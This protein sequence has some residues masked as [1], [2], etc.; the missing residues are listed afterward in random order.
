MSDLIPTAHQPAQADRLRIAYIILAHHRPEAVVRLVRRL[1][2]PDHG[3]FIHFNLRSPDAEFQRLKKDLGDLPNVKLL[4]RQKCLWGDSGMI[5]ATLARVSRSWPARILFTI[6]RCC[7]P[8]RITPSSR[9]PKSGNDWH[10]QEGQSYME[11]TPHGRIPNWEKGRAIKR[12]ENFHF[13]LPVP[14]W[15]RSLGW[16]P[17]W[18]HLTVPMKRKIPGDLHPHFG[19]AFWCLHRTCLRYIHD[20]VT[21]HPE[22][23]SF[24]QHALLP[25]ECLLQTLLMN[26]ALAPNISSRILTYV[27]WRPPWPGILTVDD[28]PELRRSDCLLAR[29][30]DTATDGK[31]LD[32]L[33]SI[34]GMA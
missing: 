14:P 29:K 13:H 12:I 1:Y 19:S 11:A 34:N 28:L 33:D 7:L 24:F 30:F 9:I 23:V 15:L 16:Q 6:M 5:H 31:I 2:A 17:M 10:Y 3:F 27:H 21:H 25:D 32:Q 8:G 22:Y 18:Q 20:Y 4:D 26:S